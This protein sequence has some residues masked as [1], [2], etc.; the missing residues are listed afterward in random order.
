MA[1][2][3]RN[4]SLRE[5]HGFTAMGSMSGSEDIP[6]QQGRSCPLCSKA[7]ADLLF[8]LRTDHEIRGHEEYARQVELADERASRA[9]G[10]KQVLKELDGL[11]AD[12]KITPE[13]YR[14]RRAAWE[15]AHPVR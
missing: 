14:T 5:C 9:D 10:L 13:E 11:R 4:E 2:T 15:S 8:H 12:G 6:H 7:P 3:P 1:S